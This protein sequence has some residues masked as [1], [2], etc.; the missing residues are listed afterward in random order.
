MGADARWGASWQEAG[1]QV[2]NTPYY[3]ANIDAS[4]VPDFF[5]TGVKPYLPLGGS[6]YCTVVGVNMELLEKIGG[7]LPTTYAEFVELAKLCK[8]NGI[9]CLST[10]GADSWVWGSCVM[11]GIIPRLTGD[12][13]WIEKAIAGEV[14]FT[15]EG[16]V[17][18]W[19]YRLKGLLREYLRGEDESIADEK[20]GK[21]REAFGMD[22][23]G[24]LKKVD[25]LVVPAN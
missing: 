7:K 15:D 9:E 5:G 18:L 24:K 8:A 21:L 25:E 20:L 12:A 10:H 17:N 13:K 19:N 23:D 14:K 6:N 3:P 11:S 4:L 2:D 16:F 22:K 1:Q